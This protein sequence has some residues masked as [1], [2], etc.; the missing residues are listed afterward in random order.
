MA[1]QTGFGQVD[2]LHRFAFEPA[3]AQAVEGPGQTREQG[4]QH[5]CHNR[6]SQG[7]GVEIGVDGIGGDA[8]PGQHKRE[9]AHLKESQPHG[10]GDDIYITE[11]TAE[12]AKDQP[13]AQGHHQHHQQDGRQ[14]VEEIGGVQQHPHR[15]EK[16]QAEKI[17]QRNNVAQGLMAVVRLAENHSRHKG[18]QGK[19]E[20]RKV[21]G[22]AYAQTNGGD[23]EQKKLTGV[24]G[25]D[26]AHH[27]GQ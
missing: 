17:A 6:H 24:P 8:D 22:V 21:G 13:F 12:N 23:G 4:R 16:E 10:Q 14:I 25:R 1:V 9:L 11:E 15:D 19:G 3:L 20:A 27:P 5:H 18:A 26:V 7:Q 2:R